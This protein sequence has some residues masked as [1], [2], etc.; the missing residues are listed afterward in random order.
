[1]LAP[2]MMANQEQDPQE[3]ND[4]KQSTS[5]KDSSGDAS[6]SS[7]GRSNAARNQRQQY[8]ERTEVNLA[9]RA[10]WQTAE[11]Q[12]VKPYQVKISFVF[13]CPSCFQDIA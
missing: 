9:E 11:I 2:M 12:F 13:S 8:G 3:N 1:M 4:D 5:E 6:S 7:R 10:R